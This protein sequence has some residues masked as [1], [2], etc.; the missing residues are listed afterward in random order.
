MNP[1]KLNLANSLKEF[2][3]AS[4]LVP[5]GGPPSRR[6]SFFV[7]GEYPI[8]FDGGKG[9]RIKDID[10]NEYI[11]YLCAY[12]PNM[13]GYRESEIDEAVI[14]Q[15]REKGF[16]FS[17]GQVYENQLAEKLRTLVPCAEMSLFV[18]S[19]SDGTT[20]AVR[21]ARAYTGRTKVMRC[22]YHGW[23]DW[24]VKDKGGIPKK[25]YEDVYEF[26]YNHLGSLESLL[27]EHGKET[28]A[29]IMTP[30][31]HPLDQP[32]QDP[33][34]G[35][36]EGVKELAHRS[37][38]VLIFD[39]V[40]TCFRLSMGGAQKY[41]GVTPDLAV[42]GKGMA[43]GYA[44]GAVVGEKEVMKEAGAEV[45]VSSTFFPNSLGH[46]AALKTIEF[47]EKNKV[48]DV[49]WEKGR[50]LMEG[51]R[52]AI[53]KYDV[54]AELSGV[55]PMMFI[56]FKKEEGTLRDQKRADFFTQ[57]IRRKVFFH[58]HHHWYVCYRH[59]EEDLGYTIQ[60]VEESLEYLHK[61]YVR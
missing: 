47:L 23:H 4:Q 53:A 34:P 40:R 11:D 58:P 24:C 12:G 48:L 57:M 22:G 56:T 16:C 37:G 42:I 9:G 8:F 26:E 61:K 45:S 1:E 49:I 10:G 25:L 3:R 15:I 2:G 51:M 44:V 39:E 52:R 7:P 20:V 35:Y 6:P 50:Y 18:I 5:G 32:M 43:N 59:T 17:L 14:G 13:I 54:G 36:L 30:Y 33:K 55:A 41:F 21:L 29:V 38:A 19:G 31:G 46:I 60:A 27:K 28:A